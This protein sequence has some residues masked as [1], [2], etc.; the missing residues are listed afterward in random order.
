MLGGHSGAYAPSSHWVYRGTIRPAGKQSRVE[1]GSK[2]TGGK[3]IEHTPWGRWDLLKPYVI[4]Q[5]LRSGLCCVASGVPIDSNAL[6]MFTL[7]NSTIS[8]TARAG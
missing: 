6:R 5:D 7:F 8:L 2:Q 3:L 4:S 1:W